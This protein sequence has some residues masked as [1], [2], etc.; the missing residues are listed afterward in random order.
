VS[1]WF[2]IARLL[3]DML[4]LNGS[5]AQAELVAMS[6]RK[7]GHNVSLIDV[8]QVAEATGTVDL[9]CVGS[10]SGSTLRPAATQLL[11]LARNLTAWHREGAWFFSVGTG[12]DLLGTHIAT[13]EGDTLPGA[14]IYPSFADH[15][16]GR[17]RGEV[18]GRDY[19]DRPFA[20]YI[21]QVGT[22][23]LQDGAKPLGHVTSSAAP[24][25][26]PEGIL[27]TRAMGTRLGGPALALNP[28]WLNDLVVGLLTQRGL[29]P[30]PTD[31]HQRIDQVATR[32]RGLIEARLRSQG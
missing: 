6:L 14:G 11:S 7:M 25:P 22:T 9:V 19:A 29:L 15:T 32:A 16:G 3:P 20:G 23:V 21:N 31:F 12:W 5:G 18:S 24:H 28:H 26:G 8:N 17:F 4:S 1:S 2:T 27:A 10:G 13:V 30:A